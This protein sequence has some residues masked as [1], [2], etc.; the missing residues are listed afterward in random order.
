MQPVGE[1]AQEY[2]RLLGFWAV[3]SHGYVTNIG[4]LLRNTEVTMNRSP[5][6]RSTVSFFQLNCD[7]RGKKRTRAIEK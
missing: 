5:C 3:F 2:V 1:C 6:F 4:R 7:K